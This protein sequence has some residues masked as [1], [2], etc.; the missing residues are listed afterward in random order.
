MT[1]SVC[2]HTHIACT[3]THAMLICTG[4]YAEN[5]SY[6]LSELVN[7]QAALTGAKQIWVGT[8][9]HTHTHTH[10]HILLLHN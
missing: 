7:D 10:T 8:R 6:S 4:I 1:H 9:T 3:Y 5:G 2:S